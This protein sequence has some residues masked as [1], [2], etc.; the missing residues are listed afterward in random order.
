MNRTHGRWRGRTVWIT[1]ASSG[2][3]RALAI[4]LAGEGARVFAS[5]RTAAALGELQQEHGIEPLPLDVTAGDDLSFAARRIRELAGHLDILVLNAGTCEY[6]DARRLDP[7]LFERVFAVNFFGAVHTLE[8]AM[9]LLRAG[10][11]RHIVGIGSAAALT[12]LPRAEAYG[13]SKAALH[14]LLDSLRL[15][16]TQEGFAVSVVM[17]G[18]VDTP[19]TARNDF[20]M[21]MRITVDEAVDHLLA[22][23]AARQPESVFPRLFVRL[24]RIFRLLP[25][26]WRNHLGQ[27]LVRRGSA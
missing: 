15:D 12:G 22:A 27:R 11:T 16:L 2:I 18:F 8:A 19:L 23:M 3:G 7:A 10:T 4:R 9:P 5:A 20:P 24:L 26:G 1:G 25:A 17:P 14:Y 6:V 21:P 13:A